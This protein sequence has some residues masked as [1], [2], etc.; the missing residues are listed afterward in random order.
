MKL[1]DFGS[2]S[3]DEVGP[4]VREE[5][6]DALAIDGSLAQGYNAWGEVKYQFD[7]DWNGAE[8]DFRQAIALDANDSQIRLAYSWFLMLDGRFEESDAQFEI[9]NEIEPNSLT[10]ATARGKMLFVSRRFDEGIEWANQL[11]A[12]E[13]NIAAPYGELCA[14]YSQKG[15][16][17]EAADALYRQLALNGRSKELI[18]R[19]QKAIETGGWKGYLRAYLSHVE[20]QSAEYRAKPS[21]YAWINTQLGEKDKAFEYLTKAIDARDPNALFIKMEPCW[22]LLRSDPRFSMLLKRMNMQ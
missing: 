3:W 13:P 6:H 22:D 11:I 15:M 9:A 20:Q 2:K 17:R 12:R 5:I 21:Y 10:A 8:A 18:A 4:I 1:P 16:Y 19:Y 14:I 7:Y